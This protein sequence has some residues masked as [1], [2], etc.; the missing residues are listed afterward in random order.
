[1]EIL[2]DTELAELIGNYQDDGPDY[3]DENDGDNED[4]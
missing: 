3:D 4:C 1:M 2:S